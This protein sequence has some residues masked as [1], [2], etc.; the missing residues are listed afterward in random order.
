[1]TNALEEARAR[2]RQR[3]EDIGIAH[4]A[5]ELLALARPAVLYRPEPAIFEGD[6]P[7][8]VS[9][10]GGKPDLPDAYPWPEDLRV[11]GSV[12]SFVVQIDLSQVPPGVLDIDLPPDGLLSVF[13][14]PEEFDI[15]RLLWSP[16]GT[17]AR[18]DPPGEARIWPVRRLEGCV[19]MTI[20]TQRRDFPR[21]EDERPFQVLEQREDDQVVQ[22]VAIPSS[23]SA[24]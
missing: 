15:G 1:M 14:H 20:D 10:I 7:V 12:L 21:V 9:K 4:W 23:S 16:P 13:A 24:R 8:G 17:L 2:F 5:T 11:P 22:W 6:I 18:R 3:F 19:E